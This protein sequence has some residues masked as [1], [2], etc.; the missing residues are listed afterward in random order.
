MREALVLLLLA[1]TACVSDTAAAGVVIPPAEREPAPDVAGVTLQ[2]DQLALEDLDG[3]VLVNFWASWCGPCVAEVPHLSAV[4][5]EFADEGVHVLG[6]NIKDQR[7]NAVA[8]EA[9]HRVTYPSLHDEAAVVA[10]SFGAIGPAGLPSTII[11]DADHNVAV[12]LFGAVTARQL[13]PYLQDLLAEP[14]AG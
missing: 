8:F 6:V 12:R 9:E 7:A 10:A 3:V 2:G 11:L 1:L 13:V 5:T 4:A 14:E